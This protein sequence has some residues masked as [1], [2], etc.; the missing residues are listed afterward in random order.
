MRALNRNKRKI[1]YALYTGN[2]VVFDEYGNETGES[3]PIY[4]DAVELRCNISAASGEDAVQ[5]FG[6]FTNYTRSVCVSDNACPITEES[7][8]WFGIEPS[9]PHNYIV[10]HKADSKNGILYALQEV[11]VRT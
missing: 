7:I 6:S 1:Y 5:A 11:K 2:E 3:K 8:I 10:T 9:E 4:G